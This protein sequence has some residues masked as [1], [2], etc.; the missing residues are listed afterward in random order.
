MLG[1]LLKCHWGG[2]IH[3]GEHFFTTK[4]VYPL[5]FF[6]ENSY[7]FEEFYTIKQGNKEGNKGK[8]K[9]QSN[10][11]DIGRCEFVV[12]KILSIENHP[13][14]DKMYVE[15]VDIG[16]DKPR[17]IVSG[18]RDYIP[19]EEM[20]DSLIVVFKNLKPAPLRDIMS[21]GMVFVANSKDM[22]CGANA[23]GKVELVRPAKDSIIGERIILENDDLTQYTPDETIKS[24][25]KN[26]PW[27][28]I[29][30]LL[31]TN[32]KLEACYNGV[33]FITSAGPLTVKSLAN[34]QIS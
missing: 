32:D 10:V 13:N 6:S 20:R 23:K 31:K 12:G 26:S 24:K 28:K 7:K 33:P 5:R 3:F 14:A 25:K 9:N 21:Y 27:M 29:F 18:L 2:S 11:P 22:D 1:R 8:N 30:P 4:M 34:S 16:E 15:M 19:I 17:Q